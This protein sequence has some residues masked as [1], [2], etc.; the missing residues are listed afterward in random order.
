MYCLDLITFLDPIDLE[1]NWGD[2]MV[3]EDMAT[4]GDGDLADVSGLFLI[5]HFLA[6]LPTQ[7]I[8]VTTVDIRLIRTF[9]SIIGESAA[10]VSDDPDSEPSSSSGDGTRPPPLKRQRTQRIGPIL[11]C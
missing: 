8:E 7:Y 4:L 2:Q 5:V 11:S 10:E 3:S 6:I 1:R 9:D